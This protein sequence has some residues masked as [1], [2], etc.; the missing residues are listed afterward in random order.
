M[1]KHEKMHDEIY[2]FYNDGAEIGR[3]ERR[4]GKIE[5]YRSKEI[6]SRYI[7]GQNVIYD[8]GGGIG[9]YAAWLAEQGNQVHLLELA[10]TA[11]AYAREH[12]VQTYGFTAETADARQ[13]PREDA[14]AD[15][16]LLMGP[17]YHL[18][19]REDRD[20][21]LGEAWRVLKPGGLLVAA[22]ISKYS[23]A[24]WALSTYSDGND[25]LDDDV[26]LNMLK[27]EISTGNHNRPESYC[28]LIAE[29][30][31]TTA[32]DMA[33]EIEAAG[34]S[35]EGKHAVE[36][37]IWFTPNLDENWER[38]DCRERLLELVHLTERDIEMM[39]MSP[40]FLIAARKK[41]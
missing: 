15:V 1:M 30:Y 17:L 31:F 10:D 19:K 36:G 39:G 26:F 18:Q 24:T 23:T 16:V 13:L 12:F 7:D 11:V 21:A 4:L 9:M 38:P 3:L 35:V 33:A 40:H 27:E 22:G 2:E 28:R 25:Y 20:M 14:T 34:F 29:A 32:Q 37:C 8:V 6:M 41:A 5:F